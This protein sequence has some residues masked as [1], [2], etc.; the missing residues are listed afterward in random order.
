MTG[1]TH[2]LAAFTLL[3]TIAISQPLPHMRLATLVVA[4]GA[5]IIGGIAPDIDQ[6]TAGLWQ[7]IPA[8]S[9]FGHIIGPLLG[10][11]RMISHSLVGVALF[12]FLAKLF[13][14]RLGGVLLVDMNVVWWSFM[15]GYFSHLL[16]D[17]VTREGVPWLFPIP[18]RL[19]FPPFKFLRMETGGILEKFIVFPGLLAANGYLLYTHYDTYLKLLRQFITK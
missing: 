10:H 18:I 13:L 4:I 11:H 16:A 7:R 8:G 19:G 15:T 12:G 1:R 14:A 17:S 3:N 9:I 5:N 6:P 2:D